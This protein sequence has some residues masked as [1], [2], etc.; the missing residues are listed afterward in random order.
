MRAARAVRDR[1]TAHRRARAGGGRR[2]SR[3][4][5]RPD[6]RVRRAGSRALDAGRDRADRPPRDAPAARRIEPGLDATRFYDPIRGT[7]AAGAQAAIVTSSPETGVITIRRWVCVEDT[8]RDHQPAHRRGPGPRGDRPGHRR[9][10][11]RAPDLRRDGTAADRHLDG[12]RDADRGRAFRLRDRARRGARRQ[13]RWACAVSARA[14]RSGRRRCWPTRSPTPWPARRRAGCAA[15]H[16]L[17]ALAACAL[18]ATRRRPGGRDA[19]RCPLPREPPR[20]AR[21]L[22]R[23]RARRRRDQA[24]RLRSSRSGAS[25]STTMRGAA[26]SARPSR[27][28]S[29]PPTGRRHQHDVADPAL[30]RGSRRAAGGPPVLGRAL[31]RAHGPDARPRGLR[32]HRPSRAGGSSSTAAARTSATTSCASTPGRATRIST[33]PTP[34]CRRRSTGR[35]PAHRHPEPFLH[36]G[37][38]RETRRRHRDPRGPLDRHLGDHGRLAL[39]QLHHAA[40]A[41]RRGLR[42]LARHAGGR[43]RAPPPTRAGPT[44]TL[45][46]SVYDYPL[47]SRFDEVDTTVVFDDVF[48]PWEQVFVYRNVD[49]VNAQFHESPAHAPANFQSLVRFGVKL[50]FMAGLALKLREVARRGGRAGHPG[51]PRRRH[52]GARARPSTRCGRPPSATRWSARATR[53]RIRSTSMPA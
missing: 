27:P 15:A 30:G 16:A 1:I 41:G 26:E 37:V 8:G 50:E 2:R 13:S 31:L 46:T 53:A 23:R 47:S 14:A 52:R 40:R 9:R 18:A 44:R 24:S 5:R 19:Q 6:Q 29:I 35:T 25:P 51:H 48:V 36:P 45:G 22:P 10:A 28:S 21:R 34:S 20:R 49:L 38:V 39:R 7:F 43:R 42:D 33:S 12:V 11:G 4:G 32:A 17:P 3:G